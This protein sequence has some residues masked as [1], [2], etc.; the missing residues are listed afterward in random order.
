MNRS[1]REKPLGW[2][3]ESY[4]HYLAAKGIRT[5]QKAYM[6]NKYYAYSPTFVAG[7]LPLIVGD[8]VGTVGASVVPLIPIIVPVMLA[9]GG[10]KI[11]A[12]RK[13]D[14]AK[15]GK[16]FFVV[17]DPVTGQRISNKLNELESL[18]GQIGGSEAANESG[19]L[20]FADRVNAG[21]ESV[22][23]E[24]DA[25]LERARDLVDKG[26]FYAK[27]KDDCAKQGKG[28]FA[29]KGV[30]QDSDA[31]AFGGAR[32]SHTYD[33][34]FFSDWSSDAQATID[35]YRRKGVRAY[36]VHRGNKHH[37]YVEDEHTDMSLDVDREVDRGNKKSFA[38]KT[39]PMT[40]EQ[41][42]PGNVYPVSPEEVKTVIERQQDT[43]GLKSVEFANPK[44]RHQEQAWA[45]YIRSR[46]AIKIFSQPR[47]EA[48]AA[49]KYVKDYVLPHEVG[50][51]RALK[52]GH[53][54]KDL[55]VAE[56]RADAN[57]IGMDP[58][59][60]DIKMLVRE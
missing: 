30:F 14:R 21:D 58:F 55:R 56:A 24:L 22:E 29:D 37:L 9:Y 23:V 38:M 34:E 18:W 12:K 35:D 47:N 49:N 40:A 25:E 7:D 11:I 43:S 48:Y 17:K 8:A 3:G 36:V 60:R 44:D 39:A 41:P 19:L 5:R 26:V 13:D 52:T 45:Q 42:R 27:R 16:G 6:S 28:F 51:H 57:V 4:R 46:K 10:A 54:D 32:Y 15:Q 1:F 31:P 20:E 53:T 33:E 50:H 59:D 2:R